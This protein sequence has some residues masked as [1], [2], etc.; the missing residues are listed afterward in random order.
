MLRLGTKLASRLVKGSAVSKEMK[1][2]AKSLGASNFSFMD[3]GAT[4]FYPQL[5]IMSLDYKPM[6]YFG[7]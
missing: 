1:L 7:S 3:T 5:E 6:R 2:I 4:Y